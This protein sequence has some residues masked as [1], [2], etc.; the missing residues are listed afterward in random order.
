[1]VWLKLAFNGMSNH[2]LQRAKRVIKINFMCR[3]RY[4]QLTLAFSCLIIR[5]PFM[6]RGFYYSLSDWYIYNLRINKQSLLIM[7]GGFIF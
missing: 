5:I 4:V 2:L 3:G 1:M 6:D 7:C